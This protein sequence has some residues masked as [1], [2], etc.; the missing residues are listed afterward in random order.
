M[1]EG[2]DAMRSFMESRGYRTLAE[3]AEDYVFVHSEK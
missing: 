1:P 3:A 2:K